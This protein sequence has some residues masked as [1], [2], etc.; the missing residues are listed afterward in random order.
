MNFKTPLFDDT[1]P[2]GFDEGTLFNIAIASMGLFVLI[3][4]TGLYF[5]LFS[6]YTYGCCSSGRKAAK[7]RS[8][9]YFDHELR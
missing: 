1:E 3:A 8:D 4:V 6:T 9:S 5:F 7:E 2:F